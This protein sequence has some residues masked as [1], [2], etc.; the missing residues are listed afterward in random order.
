MSPGTE[1]S[2]RLRRL[3][4]LLGVAACGT[5]PTEPPIEMETGSIRLTVSATGPGAPSTVLLFVDDAP[6]AAIPANEAQ[7]IGGLIVGEHEVR[8]AVPGRCTSDRYAPL[9]VEVRAKESAPLEWE[10]RCLTS[11]PPGITFHVGNTSPM[12]WIADLSGNNARLLFPDAHKLAAVP[13]LNPARTRVAY[14]SA[15]QNP[16]EPGVLHIMDGDGSNDRAL[17]WAPVTDIAW[18]P[19]GSRLAVSTES[20]VHVIWADGELD[21]SVTGLSGQE[22]PGARWSPTGNRLAYSDGSQIYLHVVESGTRITLAVAGGHSPAWAPHGGEIAYISD[23]QVR[24]VRVDGTNDRLVAV[25]PG[26][27]STLDWGENDQILFDA[28]IVPGPLRT[29]PASGGPVSI[30]PGIPLWARSG[31]WAP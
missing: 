16:R 10:I 21:V 23:N 12:P 22:S 17:P 7:V 14:A 20:E 31:R 11:V 2:M 29:V 13:V 24:A 1:H 28:A 27:L 3:A 25:A 19:D 9:P 6:P 30:L 4:L 5:S 26:I 8:I 15:S 18:S